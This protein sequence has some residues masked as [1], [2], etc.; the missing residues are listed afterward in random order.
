MEKILVKWTDRRSKGTTSLVKRSTV[1]RMITVVE[2]VEVAWGKSK[3]KYY[4]VVLNVGGECRSQDVPQLGCCAVSIPWKRKLQH[5]TT[6][7]TPQP[8]RESCVSPH[9]SSIPEMPM[10]GFATEPPP[11]MTTPLAEL[12]MYHWQESSGFESPTIPLQLQDVF[13]S[14]L[15]VSSEGG[16]ASYHIPAICAKRLQV[17]KKPGWPFN[18]K[19]LQPKRK[20]NE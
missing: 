19:N 17:T 4:A 18:R 20:R 1:K 6:G 15:N 5:V 9:L 14:Y 2:W 7:S 11:E 13:N 12:P 16:P 3:K 10:A 8:V